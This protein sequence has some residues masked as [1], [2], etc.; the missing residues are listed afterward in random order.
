MFFVGYL[1]LL[2]VCSIEV[3]RSGGLVSNLNY[4]VALT[5]IPPR[6]STI[7]FT[8]QSWLAQDILPQKIVIFIPRR[9]KRFKSRLP[10]KESDSYRD[11]LVLQLRKSNL[12]EYIDQGTLQITEVAQDWGPITKF[13]GTA[14][15][16]TTD[17]RHVDHWVYCD[18]D[19]IYKPGLSTHYANLLHT[20]APVLQSYHTMLEQ[21]R[22]E[23]TATE[24]REQISV[25]EVSP[26][27]FG[28]T[29]F[30]AE[31]R[32]HIIRTS[33]HRSEGIPHIQ[34]VDTYI[35]PS[36]IFSTAI[37]ISAV[38]GTSTHTIGELA[39]W[40][41]ANRLLRIVEHF[42]TLCPESFYQDDYLV[43]YVLYLL[44]VRMCS[45]RYRSLQCALDIYRNTNSGA[46][47][48]NTDDEENSVA[49]L[50]CNTVLNFV[51]TIEGVSKANFQMHMKE[52]VFM[53]EFI[54][55]QCL[56]KHAN[57]AYDLLYPG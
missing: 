30:A 34:G 26:A 40:N 16:H 29:M 49:G 28:F 37:D 8:L 19:M 9:Y 4:G 15:Y 3:A 1:F 46:L 6:F 43:S 23:L 22:R 33:S 18:D 55:Q 13:I 47:T 7:H 52:E 38:D 12:G 20:S 11:R 39:A 10:H 41:S 35:V 17:V 51:D 5:T 21:D 44:G 48:S 54:A 24:P 25:Q 32:V 56:T 42:H 53:R 57:V 36:S 27:L 45:A 2:L 50:D 31:H 14:L